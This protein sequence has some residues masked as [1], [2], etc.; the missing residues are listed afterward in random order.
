M[1]WLMIECDD[2]GGPTLEWDVTANPYSDF[3]K[4]WSAV[5]LL[6]EQDPEEVLYYHVR[7]GQDGQLYWGCLEDGSAG[8]PI[9][10]LAD[11]L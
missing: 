3:W 4:R 2:E 1:F 9:D 7:Q 6:E 5:L 10:S 11:I 8:T